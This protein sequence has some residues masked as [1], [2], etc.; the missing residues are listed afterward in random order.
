MK[1]KKDNKI[2]KNIINNF[3]LWTLIIVIT[4]TVLNYLDIDRK[5]KKIAYS[6]FISL[7][8][9]TN[10]NI[11]ISKATITG[12]QLVAECNPECFINNIEGGVNKFEVILPNLTIDKVSEWNDLLNFYN[13]FLIQ[14]LI[15]FIHFIYCKI[16]K[17]YFK[18]IY[19]TFYIINKAFWI[20][21]CY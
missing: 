14:Q 6:Q 16:R 15:P 17:N 21:F 7:I 10:L 12:N 1:N 9:D 18:L 20:T 11:N 4:L 3:I 13:N 19:S 5:S 2:T 8:N